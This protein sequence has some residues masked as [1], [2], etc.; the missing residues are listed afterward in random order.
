MHHASYNI[1]CDCSSF[2]IIILEKC[3]NN[4]AAQRAAEI[5]D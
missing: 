5:N 3:L 2:I 1:H 4:S